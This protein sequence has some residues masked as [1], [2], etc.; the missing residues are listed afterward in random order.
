VEGSNERA[1]AVAKNLK[2]MGMDAGII[3]EATGLPQDEVEGL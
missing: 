3:A 1:C 2:R